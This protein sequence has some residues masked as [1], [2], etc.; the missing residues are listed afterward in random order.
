M[1]G[2]IRTK[3]QSTFACAHQMVVGVMKDKGKIVY[4]SPYTQLAFEAFED[5]S[6]SAKQ[7]AIE[8]CIDIVRDTV[9]PP[10]DGLRVALEFKMNELL[11]PHQEPQQ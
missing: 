9:D 10:F 7:E 6:K 8:R 2:D 11:T 3:F 1:S 4:T 5:G